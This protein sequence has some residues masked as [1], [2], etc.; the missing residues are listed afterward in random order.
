VFI[1]NRK[2]RYSKK[3]EKGINGLSSSLRIYSPKKKPKNNAKFKGK[4]E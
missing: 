1:T 4:A 3:G 2:I